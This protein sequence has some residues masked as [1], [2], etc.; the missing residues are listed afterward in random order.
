MR[1]GG[2]T[3]V[4]GVLYGS[5]AA[6]TP[7]WQ[8]MTLPFER[9]AEALVQRMTLEEK[10]SQMMDRAPAIERLGIP[11]YNWW[12]E[13]LHGVARSGL[14][15]VFPQAIGFAATWDDSL[16]FRMATVISDEFRAKHHDYLRR[17]EHQRYQG[18]TIWSP[19][20]NLFRDPRW[21]RGQETYGEDPYLTG[22][23]AVPFIRGL[24]GDDPR[25]LKTIATVKHFAVHSGPEPLRHQFDAVVSERDLRESYLPHFETGIREGGAYSLMCAYNRVFGAPACASDLLLRTILHGE[26]RFPGYVV[27]DCG[28][29]DDIY[30][31]HRVVT[32]AAEAA[33][34]AVR[35]GTDLDCGREYTSLL[36]A[37]R[38]NLISERAIDSAVTRLFLARFRLGMFDTP[39]SV[40]W[41]RI[42]IGVLDQPS[43]RA[44]ALQVAHESIVLLK[45]NRNLLPLRR[46]VLFQVVDRVQRGLRNLRI[47][48]ADRVGKD[49][50]RHRGPVVRL[51]LVGLGHRR[52]VIQLTHE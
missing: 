11:E 28:A 10:I 15:T 12:N 17:G 5:A 45:N 49:G 30:Q 26:W 48:T 23:L 18:L 39:D 46:E 47:K 43:H 3:L 8:D 31:R 52:Q 27:S 40:R 29:I 16:V 19:N 33:A 22:R 2:V 25:Y 41:A 21:G 13:G 34:R 20:I 9:R 50:V 32:T 14:A 37:V 4:C 36:D 44:L 38:Q 1:V 35:S 51:V 42:P 6:Q 7:A 24:Q